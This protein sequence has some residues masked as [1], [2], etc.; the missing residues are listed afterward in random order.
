[1]RFGHQI[2][3]LLSN[4]S[5]IAQSTQI[6]SL[7]DV[8]PGQHAIGKTVFA[9]SKVEEF[10][11]EILGIL[12]NL[13]PKQNLI[14]GKLSGGPLEKTGVMQGM[15]GSPV[16]LN[17]KLLGAVAM[18]F[19]FAK[20]AIA[21]IRPIE[22]ML[23]ADSN[24][25]L[26][27]LEPVRAT[28][29]GDTK[30]VDIATPVSFTGF[31]RA[32]IEHFSPMLRELGLEPRQGVAGGRPTDSVTSK[33]K[34]LEP[35]EMISV[36]LVSGDMS[37]GADGTLTHIDGKKIY[38]F[39]HR[40]M[41]LGEAEMPFARS[42]VI[43]L[44]ANL[45]TSFKISS[46]K[47]WFGSIMSDRNAA[48]SGEIGRKANLLPVTV[49]VKNLS[50]PGS[51]HTYRMQLVR[52]RFLSPLLLQMAVFSAIEGTERT[53]GAATVRISG[54]ILMSSGDPILVENQYAADFGAPVQA[55]IAAVLPVN[56]IFQSRL[57]GW[58]P[59]SMEFNIEA[60]ETRET[61]QLDRF[62]S[63][64]NSYRPG[65]TAE[66]DAV[67]RKED[68][69]E[70]RRLLHFPIPD[71]ANAGNLFAS[72]SD[73]ATA[74]GLENRLNFGAAP[75]NQEQA[76]QFLKAQRT[77]SSAWVR[78]WRA[79]MSYDVSGEAMPAVPS[80]VALLFN[81]TQSS[82]GSVQPGRPSKLAEFEIPLGEVLGAVSRTVQ[83][84][85]KP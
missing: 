81:K 12:E 30:L 44:L 28:I 59:E 74:N 32:T 49:N 14:L 15:S 79:E 53:L 11:V 50:R 51:A 36:Q 37:V 61:W 35:G 47:Q 33:T 75:R 83:I 52:D 6:L 2:L 82:Q 71:G 4:L 13:G 25:P 70:L 40:F 26:E 42:E 48:V 38:A 18:A 7:K 56:F 65:E 31:T 22:E 77:N 62:Y 34:P 72:L 20:D 39:G 78:I 10:Q 46:A 5:L 73:G 19:P 17:G 24:P 27:R 45:S 8:H 66:F 41:G 9:G 80:S 63:R 16:Y 29:L 64:R 3:F 55:A 84:E 76:R 57:P 21:G 54:K 67:F 23:A 60:R 69:T 68:G 1:M 58:N 85:I 43:T